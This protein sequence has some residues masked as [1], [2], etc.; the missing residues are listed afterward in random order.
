MGFFDFF[1]NFEAFQSLELIFRRISFGFV[2]LHAPFMYGFLYFCDFLL[3]EIDFI[4]C[5]IESAKILL[6]GFIDIV[7]SKNKLFTWVKIQIH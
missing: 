1:F 5:G 6:I 2:E 3:I 4:A 7:P